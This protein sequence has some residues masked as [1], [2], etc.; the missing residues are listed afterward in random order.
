MHL[1][2]TNQGKVTCVE[3]V[4]FLGNEGDDVLDECLVYVESIHPMA[5]L[6]LPCVSDSGVLCGIPAVDVG[7]IFLWVLWFGG[8]VCVWSVAR[9]NVG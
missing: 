3:F 8:I 1:S 2:L 5:Y 6:T 9:P 7:W 4:T